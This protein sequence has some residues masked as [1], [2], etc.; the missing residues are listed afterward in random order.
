MK[1]ASNCEVRGPTDASA[2]TR[3][4]LGPPQPVGREATGWYFGAAE[5]CMTAPDL[6]RW[7][8]AFLQKRILSAKSYSEFTNEVK[9]ADGKPTHYA[10][11]LQVGDFH[12]TPQVMHSGEVSGFLA[13]TRVFPAKGA[14]LD[15]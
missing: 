15:Y 7:D 5:L 10:L 6:A 3:F 14:N 12:G 9:L 4:A 11:G 8:A 1:S 13:I 2:Y